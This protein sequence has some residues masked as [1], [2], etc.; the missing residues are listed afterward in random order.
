[1]L[2]SIRSCLTLRRGSLGKSCIRQLG[3]WSCQ[4]KLNCRET[5]G[6]TETEL[7][8][9]G[10]REQGALESHRKQCSHRQEVF[11]F[12]SMLG[13]VLRGT[14]LYQPEGTP[15]ISFRPSENLS[16]KSLQPEP[17][18]TSDTPRKR[19]FCGSLV[20]IMPQ[21]GQGHEK[22]RKGKELSQTTREEEDLATAC[23]GYPGGTGEAPISPRVN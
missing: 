22:Q 18:E 11:L 4:P 5:K 2:V 7:G 3:L 10:A 16:S 6:R 17:E 21:E 12:P 20:V 15:S 14:P 8:V 13:Q 9:T 1:M 23:G 19:A